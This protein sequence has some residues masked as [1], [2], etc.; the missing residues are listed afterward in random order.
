M[1]LSNARLVDAAP[2]LAVPPKAARPHAGAPHASGAAPAAPSGG[3]VDID[4]V[5]GE[6][7]RVSP[8]GSTAS[9]GERHDLA[10]ATVIPGLWDEHT[11]MGQW[12]RH[13][14]RPSVL[15]VAS[16][17]EAAAVAGAAARAHADASGTEPL[18]LV[19]MRDA[20]WPA[21]PTRAMLDAATGDVP[22]L[23]VSSDVH[24]SWPSSA[25]LARLGIPLGAEPDAALLREDAA[26]DALQA[27]E[28]MLDADA[29]DRHVVDALAVAAGRGIVGVVDLEFDDAVG[30]WMRAGRATPTRVEVGIYQQD[31]ELAAERGVRTGDAVLPPGAPGAARARIGRLKVISDGALGTRTAWTSHP[32]DDGAGHAGAGVRN[33]DDEDLDRLLARATELGLGAAIHA[34]GDAAV[35]AAIDALERAYAG[36]R[37]R[38]GDRIE[39]AQLVGAADIPRLA[40]NGI[41]ASLQPEHALDDRELTA[42]LWADRSGDAY[43]IRSLVDAGV[44][45]VLGSDAPVTPLDPWR[46]IATAV[47]RT[48]DDEQPWQPQEAITIAE[49]IAASARTRVAAGE[50]A[51]LVVLADALPGD[52]DVSRD[53][54]AAAARL[55]AATARVTMI[56]GEVVH[57]A[58]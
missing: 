9:V 35:T 32:Y 22:T 16:A 8:A 20:L 55:R 45:V 48:R 19:G 4:I 28:G 2:S 43:R 41:V 44:R 47:T 18:V 25:M 21:P 58:L 10:G 33:V 42:A 36:G 5:D 17:E 37:P 38:G 31:L 46:A 27:V 40:R 6:I 50:P 57:G 15:E 3:L 7:E 54:Q 49:A 56:A 24:S 53:P 51:D 1:R 12:A 34:I 13:R 52:D 39:H 30:A 14:M 11:H 23:I 29:L 26:F